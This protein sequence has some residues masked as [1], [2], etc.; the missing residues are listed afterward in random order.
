MPLLGRE[1]G[2]Q[3]FRDIDLNPADETFPG[4]AVIRLDGG[5]FFATAEALDERIREII[6]DGPRHAVIDLEGVAFVDSQGAAKLTEIANSP[7]AAESRWVGRVKQDRSFW[8]LR[9]SSTDRCGSRARRRPP[10]GGGGALGRRG[11]VEMTRPM[12]I[13]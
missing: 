4:I 7:T 9:A 2:T 10:G 13:A 8:K 12:S 1:P 11:N 3:V 5:L 6:Q